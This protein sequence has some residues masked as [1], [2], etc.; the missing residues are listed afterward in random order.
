MKPFNLKEAKAGAKLCTR[1]GRNARVIC[2]DRAYDG[3]EIVALV[4]AGGFE[5][6]FPYDLK[7]KYA[8]LSEEHYNDL[9]MEE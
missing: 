7:G 6:L 3:F 8:G 4:R 9:M 5:F 2:W 1:D